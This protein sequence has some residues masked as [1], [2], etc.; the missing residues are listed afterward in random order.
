MR[1]LIAD[2]H[3]M[4]RTALRFI[5]KEAYPSVVLEEVDNT[6]ELFK[7]AIKEK[8]DLVLCDITFPGQSGLEALKQ[9]KSQ[10]PKLPVLM[11]S[12]HTAEEYAVRCITA[13]SSGY[14]SKDNI[15]GELVKA[16]DQIMA[17]RR[18]LNMEVAEILAASYEKKTKTIAH[19]SLSDREYQIFKMLINGNTM[20]EVAE[21]LSISINTV[22]SHKV[23]IQKKMNLQSDAEMIKYGIDHSL[24]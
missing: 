9:I 21:K 22:R 10:V 15:S 6:V 17:G 7:R 4:V 2:D 16:I 18:Y 24:T 5:L 23:H 12:M 1:I 20:Q 14:L 8:W 19:E 11:L 13:G 3:K